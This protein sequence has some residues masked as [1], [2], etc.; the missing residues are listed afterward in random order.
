MDSP[1]S[2]AAFVGTISVHSVVKNDLNAVHCQDGGYKQVRVS[3]FQHRQPKCGY[4]PSFPESRINNSGSYYAV[5]GARITQPDLYISSNLA[6]HGIEKILYTVSGDG[7]D[8]LTT[9]FQPKPE[10]EPIASSALSR[11]L[12]L[13]W[14]LL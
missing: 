3:D 11:F 6:V 5:D 7:H 10:G 14:F 4:G 12:V 13:S 1:S 8:Q 2:F 9:P